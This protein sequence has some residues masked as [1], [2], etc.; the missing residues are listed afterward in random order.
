M[1]DALEEQEFYELMQAYRHC[2]MTDFAGVAEAFEA[3][4]AYVRDEADEAWLEFRDR[5]LCGLCANTG[6]VN[7]RGMRSPA[8][9]TCGVRTFCI[10]P[11]GRAMKQQDAAIEGGWQDGR[12][13]WR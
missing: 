1:S 2:P 3:V 8:G 11:N 13:E 9:V 7:T 12:G 4:K 10:C 6:I 5:M